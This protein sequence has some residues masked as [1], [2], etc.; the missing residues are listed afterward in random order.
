MGKII[1]LWNRLNEPSTHA[2]ILAL[3][4]YFHINPDAFS[5][6]EGL[7]ALVIGGLGVFVSEGDPSAKVKGFN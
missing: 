5:N 1:Y 2:T 3:V 7:M 6:Y 4:A